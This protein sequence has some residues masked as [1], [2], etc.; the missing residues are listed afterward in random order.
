[1]RFKIRGSHLTCKVASKCLNVRE[2]V[3]GVER[4]KDGFL[5]SPAV[6]WIASVL[7]RKSW[8]K[9]VMEWKEW[10][11][12][13]AKCMKNCNCEE[14]HTTNG[15]HI[16]IQICYSISL[17][18]DY[19]QENNKKTGWYCTKLWNKQDLSNNMSRRKRKNWDWR[20]I[21]ILMPFLN[22]KSSKKIVWSFWI[23]EKKGKSNWL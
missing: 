8:Y 11:C 1:M 15:G 10:S 5:P 14:R 16:L 22:A 18:R 7:E 21:W 13:F 12:C 4:N 6:L 17:V 2:R 9:K 19:E 20:K 3:K 23:S